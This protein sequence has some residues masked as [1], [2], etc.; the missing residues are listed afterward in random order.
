[1]KLLLYHPPSNLPDYKFIASLGYRLHAITDERQPVAHGEEYEVIVANSL[2]LHHDLSLFPNLRFI[3]LRSAGIDRVPLERIRERGI[4]LANAR[5]VYSVPI[6]EWV[7]AKI[8]EIYKQSRFFYQAQRLAHWEKKRDVREICGKTAGIVGFGSIGQ[9]IARRLRAFSARILAFDIVHPHSDLADEYYPVGQLRER[10]RDCD[11][12][13]FAVPLTDETCRLGNAGLFAAMRDG[14]VLVN[15]SR[16]AVIDEVALLAS[17]VRGKFLGVALDVFE[18]EPLPP[19]S[20][21]WGRPEVLVSPHNA[22]LSDNVDAR[23]AALIYHNLCRYAGGQ[24]LLNTIS[25]QSPPC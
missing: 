17:L 6:A 22:F 18:Q 20:P 5:G 11:I 3:Q 12:L 16:G 2:F 4:A 7:V 14:A 13:V 9:E 15:V 25:P 10:A 21:L 1:M 19:Y 8:L 24:D 23:L